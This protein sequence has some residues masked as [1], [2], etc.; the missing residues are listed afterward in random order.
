MTSRSEKEATESL[1]ATLRRLSEL[2]WK[3]ANSAA[4]NALNEP[5]EHIRDLYVRHQQHHIAESNRLMESADWYERSMNSEP[6]KKRS[7]YNERITYGNVSYT[8]PE[9]SSLLGISQAALYYRRK[10]GWPV[11]KMLGM[12]TQRRETAN[13]S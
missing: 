3:R 10:A 2:E 8:I 6:L 7:Q 13:A 1:V 9:W 12:A 4:T 5:N 11:P